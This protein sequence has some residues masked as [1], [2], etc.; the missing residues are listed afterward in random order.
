MLGKKTPIFKKQKSFSRAAFR[1]LMRKTAPEV[2]G[3][4]GKIYTWRERIKMEKKV[5]PPG[6]FKSQISE[7]GVK[8]RLRELNMERFKAKS[9]KEKALINRKISFLREVTGIK[10]Y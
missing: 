4:D 10:P 3:S 5:W 1:E 8:S 9:N 2:P 7:M 6:T